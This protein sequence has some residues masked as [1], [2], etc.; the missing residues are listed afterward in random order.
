MRAGGE[1]G[2]RSP[3]PGRSAAPSSYEH[4][5]APAPS[6]AG[7]AAPPFIPPAGGAGGGSGG[8]LDAP[9]LWRCR[10][11]TTPVGSRSRPYAPERLLPPCPRR[12]VFLNHDYLI[13][14]P[15]RCTQASKESRGLSR[16]VRE[17]AHGSQQLLFV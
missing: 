10:A 5:L 4:T 7:P 6:G 1:C 11:A 12:A 9:L 2:G 3:E 17:E 8:L 14:S 15:L 16:Q 13:R